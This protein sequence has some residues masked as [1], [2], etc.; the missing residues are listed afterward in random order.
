MARVTRK[1]ARKSLNLAKKST[2]K[3]T[4]KKSAGV[5]V[6]K[7]NVVLDG[8][9]KSARTSNRNN[10]SSKSAENLDNPEVIENSTEILEE[11]PTVEEIL[12]AAAETIENTNSSSAAGILEDNL[13]VGENNEHQEDNS[14][15]QSKLRKSKVK[16]GKMREKVTTLKEQITTLEAEVQKLRGTVEAVSSVLS[17]DGVRSLL[18]AQFGKVSLV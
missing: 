5:A 17:K 15:L 18:N 13:A 7:Q 11:V 12:P 10:S 1:V 2:D 6:A 14:E 4:V 9:R 8:A 3:T 16:V